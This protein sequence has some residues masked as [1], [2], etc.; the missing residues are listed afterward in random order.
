MEICIGALVVLGAVV[1]VYVLAE[2]QRY[3]QARDKRNARNAEQQRVEECAQVVHFFADHLGYIARSVVGRD[4]LAELIDA[5][6]TADELAD[7]IADRIAEVDALELGVHASIGARVPVKLM[8][9]YRDRHIY[10]VGKSGTGKTTL[11]RSMIMQ[12]MAAGEGIGV[13][14]PERE[15]IVDELLPFVPEHRMRDV[16]YFNPGDL[17]RPVSFNPLALEEG[18][19]IDRRVDENVTIFKRLLS[20]DSTPRIDELMRQAFYALLEIPGTTLLD[21]PRLLDVENPHYRKD[22]IARL[23][24]GHTA[25]FWREVYPSF[26]KNAHL[27]LVYRMSRFT[28]SKYI[29]SILCQP[30]TTLDFRHVMDEGKILLCNLSDGVLGEQN[31]QLLG[32]LIVSK[33]QLAVM[34]RAS[35]PMHR[36]R[37]FYLYVDEFQTFTGTSSTSYEKILSRARKYRLALVLAHQQ[38][39]QIPPALLKEILGNV[40]TMVSFAISRDDARRLSGEF[41]SK[42]GGEVEALDAGDLLGLRVGETYCRIGTTSFPMYTERIS[43]RP[44]S[45]R[46]EEVIE[47]SRMH[48]GRPAA[49]DAG[50]GERTDASED[51]ENYFGDIDPGEVFG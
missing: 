5:G 30:E 17:E 28:R 14:A 27:P 31:S 13:I 7:F 29:R 23:T 36:R 24:D 32:Q 26:P 43:E 42:M 39:S 50:P 20:G 16:I 12:D 41:I 19:D 10:I 48:Y 6:I 18:E 46:R 2:R 11:L 51:E 9:H 49:R 44:D 3:A 21:V 22:V 15:M 35:V 8:E 25:Q 4:D 47:L 40:S 38:T 33:L 45:E 1:V 34:G 37:R